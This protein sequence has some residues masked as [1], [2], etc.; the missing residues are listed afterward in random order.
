M[1][2]TAGEARMAA[3]VEHLIGRDAAGAIADLDAALD[4]GVDVGQLLEQ[5]LG[6]FRD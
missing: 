1:L 4:E 5:L 2:G 6:Y 3:L